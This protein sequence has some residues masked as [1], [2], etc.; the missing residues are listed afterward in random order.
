M[1]ALRLCLGS[2]RDSVSGFG[3]DHLWPA[4]LGG[5]RS[6]IAIIDAAGVIHTRPLGRN[7]DVVAAVAEERA[8]LAA[9]HLRAVAVPQLIVAAMPETASAPS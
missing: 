7:Y 9:Y 6:R 2:F 8:L 5:A 1:R 4:L 3:L